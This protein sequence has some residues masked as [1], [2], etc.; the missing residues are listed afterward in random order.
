MFNIEIFLI[1]EKIEYRTDGKNV[2]RNEINVCCPYCGEARFHLGINSQKNKFNCWICSEK[3]D[4]VKF[5]SKLKN[6]SFLEA[7]QIINPVSDL[8]RAL[9]N[10]KKIEEV[11]ESI[12]NKN[13]KLPPYTKPFIKGSP[14]I[15]QNAAYK[16]LKSKYNLSWEQILEADLHYCYFGKYG[17]NIIVPFYSRTGSLINFLGRTWDKKSKMRY[18]NCKNEEAV[19]KMKDM[20]YTYNRIKKGLP[21][22]IIVE[23]V[24]D[25]IK[26][27]L[28]RAVAL[29]GSEVTQ[30]QKNLII[31]LKP[32]KT[33]VMFDNDPHLKT[34]SIKA[35]KLADYL[36]AFG[37]SKVIQLPQG[38]DPGDLSIEEIEKI[39]KK[40]ETN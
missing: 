19:V 32:K 9:E 5:I 38:K 30:K 1:Q 40:Y 24:F 21:C 37:E 35:K 6:I 20:V 36:S 4:L 13:L 22:L 27:G 29:C 26:V 15:W 23:G 2:G 12:K 31:E 3:G 8:K 33:L 34:T 39:I 28:D 10:R 16:F 11:Q 17:N 25:A 14:N 7:K 18:K